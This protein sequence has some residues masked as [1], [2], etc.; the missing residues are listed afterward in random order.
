M[1][2]I[3]C[4]HYI[5]ENLKGNFKIAKYDQFNRFIEANIQSASEPN[6]YHFVALTIQDMP[7][8]AKL[9]RLIYI[10]GFCDSDL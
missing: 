5:A 1:H 7:F 6:R 2:M 10:Q 8:K 4:P 9:I 3:W